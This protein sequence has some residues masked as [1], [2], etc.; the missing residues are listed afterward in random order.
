MGNLMDDLDKFLKSDA[1]RSLVEAGIVRINSSE[2]L[3]VDD[4]PELED[5]DLESME[6]EELEDL[7][8]RL[9]DLQNTLEEEEP[10]DED[11]EEYEL[12]EGNIWMLEDFS[13]EVQDRIDKLRSEE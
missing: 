1:I 4:I 3:T 11:S 6:L 10:E 8:D 7:Q 5:M 9:E 2:A 13:E 12:W